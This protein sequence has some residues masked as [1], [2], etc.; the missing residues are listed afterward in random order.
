MKVLL[1]PHSLSWFSDLA[2]PYTGASSLL[3]VP[4]NPLLFPIVPSLL[5]TSFV[6]VYDSLCLIM[7]VS[8]SIAGMLFNRRKGKFLEGFFP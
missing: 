1:L 8:M 5:L 2:F 6:F 4:Q 3:S 7:T